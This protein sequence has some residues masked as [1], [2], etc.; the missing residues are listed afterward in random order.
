MKYPLRSVF[1]LPAKNIPG[2]TTFYVG[3]LSSPAA[4]VKN[5]SEVR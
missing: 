3:S 5:M 2:M 4:K 1:F